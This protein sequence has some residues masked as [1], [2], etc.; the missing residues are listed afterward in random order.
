[1]IDNSKIDTSCTK[2]EAP[3]LD[4]FADA[5]AGLFHGML[6]HRFDWLGRFAVGTSEAPRCQVKRPEIRFFLRQII[7]SL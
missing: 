2:E 6:G 1:M 5:I 3:D 7:S 4:R